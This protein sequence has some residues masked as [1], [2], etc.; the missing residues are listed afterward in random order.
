MSTV[1]D[2]E[3]E[4]SLV[5]HMYHKVFLYMGKVHLNDLTSKCWIQSLKE[6][7]FQLRHSFGSTTKKSQVIPKEVD[8]PCD[9]CG[10]ACIDLVNIE[11]SPF[12]DWSVQS[13]KC[14]KW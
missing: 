11:A 7:T 6:K 1:F 13:D 3:L 14:D 4:E 9:V 5:L 2:Y 10:K 8:Y 12:E